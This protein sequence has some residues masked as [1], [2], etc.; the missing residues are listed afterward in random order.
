MTKCAWHCC[1]NETNTKFCS[2]KCKN[3]FHVDLK[4]KRLRIQAL[5]Y[6]GNKCLICGYNHCKEA[7][8]FHHINPSEK[9]FGIS[10]NGLT[11]SWKVIQ[12]ELDKC[13]CVCNRCHREI[14][15]NLIDLSKY[16]SD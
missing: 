2:I 9:D 8:E 4:R 11:R 12:P 10:A 7:L 1:H 5:E 6:M 3:K 16:I 15:S 13:I 14:H